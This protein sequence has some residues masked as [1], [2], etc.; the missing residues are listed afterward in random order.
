[1]PR[2]NSR[3]GTV[4]RAGKLGALLLVTSFLIPAATALAQEMELRGTSD[5]PRRQIQQHGIPAPAYRPVNRGAE[6]EQAP[7]ANAAQGV[8]P[9]VDAALDAPPEP[10]PAR[11]PP[12]PAPEEREE[13]QAPNPRAGAVNPEEISRTNM[14]QE[15]SG[16]LERGAGGFE[17][18][19]FQAPGIRMGSFMLRPSFEQGLTATSNASGSAGGRSAVLSDTTLRLGAASDWSRHSADITGYATWRKSVS[20][21]HLD[22]VRGRIDAT[23]N[24]DLDRDWRAMARLGYES[25][26]ESASSPL[27]ITGTASQPTRHRIDGSIGVEKAL[28]KLRVGLTGEAQRDL[29]EDARLSSGG[30]LS[31]KHRDSTLYTARLRTG[32][33]ISPA[34]TPFVQ[35]EGGR[36]VYDERVDP[37]TYR[38]SADRIGASIGTEFDLGEKFGGEV[39]AGWL[40]ESFDDDRLRPLSAATLDAAL[41]WSPQRGTDIGLRGTTTLEGSTTAGESGSVLYALR[42]TGDRQIR[43]NLT[44]NA[45]LGLD[46]RDYSGSNDRDLVY[47][48]EAGLTWWMNRYMGLTVRARHETLDSNIAGRDSKTNSIYLGITARR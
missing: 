15:R 8:D 45:A 42:L 3:F 10:A 1:M 33:E 46:W 11:R 30:K 38:R 22:E 27:A 20:G 16:A 12:A 41:R 9:L 18:D 17:D 47:S 13:G 37:G 39:A 44:A 31:Q 43:A 28:G 32:Y 7:D 25:S 40:R 14:R 5:S 29:Y 26:P 35:I 48:A 21:E 2:L 36:R 23:L 24:L 6:A 4:Q 19:P 34:L